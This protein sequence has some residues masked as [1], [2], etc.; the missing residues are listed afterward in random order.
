MFI[1]I[2]Y[3]DVKYIKT[4]I[5]M[6]RFIDAV[7]YFRS[8]TSHELPVGRRKLYSNDVP[9]FVLHQRNDTSY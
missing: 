5:R 1:D 7:K 8:F 2:Y 3:K 4:H 9:N 6:S